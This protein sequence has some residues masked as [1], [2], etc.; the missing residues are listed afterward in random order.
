MIAHEASLKRM[1]MESGD[2]VYGGRMKINKIQKTA[3]ARP[4]RQK[5]GGSARAFAYALLSSNN[6][7]MFKSLY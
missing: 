4:N 5:A 1:F 3:Q 2:P 6:D 7:K